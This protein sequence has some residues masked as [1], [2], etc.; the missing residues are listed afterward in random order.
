MYLLVYLNYSK[1]YL[2]C[3]F[4][5]HTSHANADIL[6]NQFIRKTY[7]K[8]RLITIDGSSSHKTPF[9]DSVEYK[10]YSLQEMPA[11]IISLIWYCV[12]ALVC[13]L[14]ACLLVCLF[15]CLLAFLLACLLVCLLA[16]LLAYLHACLLACLPSF[17]FVQFYTKWWLTFTRNGDSKITPKWIK[18][19]K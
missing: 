18:N 1:V 8:C 4:F 19:Q 7:T 15:A 16:Y 12:I 10:F 5:H 13:C 11:R 6:G 2:P 3:V 14:F 9:H 17:I